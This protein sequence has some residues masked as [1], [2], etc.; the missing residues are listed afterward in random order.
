MFL[1]SYSSGNIKTNKI[2]PVSACLA[3]FEVI[4]HFL[5]TWTWQP[6]TYY[7]YCLLDPASVCPCSFVTCM[8]DLEFQNA[9]ELQI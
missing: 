2:Q 3:F 5:F 6:C 9:N 8:G 4:W 7:R 1:P